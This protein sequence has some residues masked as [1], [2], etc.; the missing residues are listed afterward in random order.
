VEP[1]RFFVTGAGAAIPGATTISL[2]LSGTALPY[3]VGGG[4][5]I[6]GVAQ[7]FRTVSTAPE[8]YPHNQ[9]L[10]QP[11]MAVESFTL[12]VALLALAV[13]SP[14]AR[15]ALRHLAQP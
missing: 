3:A 14:W 1:Q 9:A 8:T 15:H 4:T 13:T 10:E 6:V 7:P 5:A 2:S 12:V 11:P